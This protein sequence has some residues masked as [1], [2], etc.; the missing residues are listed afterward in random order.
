M[1]RVGRDEVRL[2]NREWSGY[3]VARLWSKWP[4]SGQRSGQVIP[5][6]PLD[7]GDLEREE[8]R[9]VKVVKLFWKLL[10]GE[11]LSYK[12][13]ILGEEVSRKVWPLWPLAKDI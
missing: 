7:L 1:V 8:D 6:F 9:V 2:E 12:I 11:K 10:L 5:L 13:Y 4:S 3:Q